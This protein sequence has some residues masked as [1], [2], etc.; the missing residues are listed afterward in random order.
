MNPLASSQG[1]TSGMAAPSPAVLKEP[2][3]GAPG[4]NTAIAGGLG[5]KRQAKSGAAGAAQGALDPFPP[6]SAGLT[7]GAHLGLAR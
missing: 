1:P 3:P 6:H 7:S 2:Q 5:G 4:R